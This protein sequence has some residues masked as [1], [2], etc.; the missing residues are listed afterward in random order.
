M[1]MNPAEIKQFL[2][3]QIPP[4]ARRQAL[5]FALQAVVADE[6]KKESSTESDLLRPVVDRLRL[7]AERAGATPMGLAGLQMA[8]PKLLDQLM[9]L[10]D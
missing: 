7:D 5:L 8:A 1:A 2:K 9:A 10:L 3:N 4:T 6:V